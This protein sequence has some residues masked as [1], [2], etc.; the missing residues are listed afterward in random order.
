ME[1]NCGMV[2]SLSLDELKTLIKSVNKYPEYIIVGVYP[3][4]SSLRM[5]HILDENFNIKV[6]FEF[7]FQLVNK[8]PVN[9]KD[10]RDGVLNT[11]LY[12]ALHDDITDLAIYRED[13]VYALKT[14]GQLTLSPGFDW[15]SGLLSKYDGVVTY[16][17]LSVN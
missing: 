6:N 3:R 15:D 17:T 10:L 2:T 9:F 8:T 12:F 7:Y 11:G 4:D 5:R 14:Q 16:E 13:F 1:F